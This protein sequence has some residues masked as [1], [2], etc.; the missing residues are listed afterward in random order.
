PEVA[1]TQGWIGR[2]FDNACRGADPTV[3]ISIGRQMPLAFQSGR[4]LGISLENPESYRYASD[5]DP[6]EGEMRSESFYRK[7]NGPEMLDGSDLNSGGSIAAAPGSAVPAT[8][9]SS[10]DFLERVALDAQVSSDKIL[11][12]TK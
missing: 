3:G 9:G 1:R 11:A 5:D 12:V 6:A 10:L 2:F 8:R 4:P 7:L